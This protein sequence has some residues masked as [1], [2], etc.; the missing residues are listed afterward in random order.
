MATLYAVSAGLPPS[1][2][3]PELTEEFVAASRNA[4]KAVNDLLV[5]NVA[6]Q[7]IRCGL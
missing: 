7:E 5:A 4:G 1:A 6:C 2:G 3:K